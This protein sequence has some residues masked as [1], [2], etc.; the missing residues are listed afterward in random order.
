MS[1]VLGFTFGSFGD[2]ITLIQLADAV[3]KSLSET[4]GS[5]ANCE[6]LMGYLDGFSQS[7]EHVMKRLEP[8]NNTGSRDTFFTLRLSPPEVGTILFHIAECYKVLDDFSKTLGPYVEMVDRRPAQSFCEKVRK[9]WRKLCWP[10]VK[11]EAADVERRLTALTT[12]ITLV[13][14]T[15]DL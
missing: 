7:L 4:R 10:Q 6:R 5:V 13:L 1:A 8:C 9:F 11:G 2:I 14:Q 3:R 12:S 15:A